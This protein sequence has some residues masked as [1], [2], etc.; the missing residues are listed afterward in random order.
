MVVQF[1]LQVL[2]NTSLWKST[3][4]ILVLL[5]RGKGNSFDHLTTPFAFLWERSTKSV[6]LQE[7]S[8]VFYSVP[9]FTYSSS[10]QYLLLKR[11][12]DLATL[13]PRHQENAVAYQKEQEDRIG[14]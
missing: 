7:N 14:R 11:W 10:V 13:L 6:L 5:G 1:L 12:E 2:T 9:S 8:A 4:C 3:A